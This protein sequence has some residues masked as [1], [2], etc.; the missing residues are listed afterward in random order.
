[1]CVLYRDTKTTIEGTEIRVTISLARPP[2]QLEIKDLSCTCV[3][4]ESVQT[5]Y[6]PLSNGTVVLF[7]W[8]RPEILCATQNSAFKNHPIE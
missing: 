1:M 7:K 6:V 3:T 2:I 8:D 4:D 5:F